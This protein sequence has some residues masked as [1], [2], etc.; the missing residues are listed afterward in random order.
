MCPR[1]V[2]SSSMV[3]CINLVL[4]P[5]DEA[6]P[7]RKLWLRQAASTLS[8]PTPIPSQYTGDGVPQIWRPFR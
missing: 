1:P 5:L 7:L 4:I 3:R 8:W 2:C 6:T